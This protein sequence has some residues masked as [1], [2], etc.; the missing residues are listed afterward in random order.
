MKNHCY[1]KEPNSSNSEASSAYLQLQIYL[2]LLPY[3]A[4][5]FVVVLPSGVYLL[6]D[7]TENSPVCVC[8]CSVTGE[9]EETDRDRKQEEAAGR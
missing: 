7:L 4:T 6:C 2:E 1:Q 8:V 5:V 3:L 9:E